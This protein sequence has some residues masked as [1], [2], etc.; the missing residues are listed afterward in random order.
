MSNNVAAIVERLSE[1]DRVLVAEKLVELDR[2]LEQLRKQDAAL[3]AGLARSLTAPR[4][5]D[6]AH[7]AVREIEKFIRD[8]VRQE[9]KAN[10]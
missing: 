6:D 3:V 5:D 1:A 10:A 7:R 8:I 2:K 9:L 4:G